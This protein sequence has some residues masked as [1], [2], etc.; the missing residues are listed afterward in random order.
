M[1][2]LYKNGL[3]N[4]NTCLLWS[5]QFIS[6]LG[7]S[8]SSIGIIF[9]VKNH[10][11]SAFHVGIIQSIVDLAP[12][13]F[14]LLSGVFV[15]HFRKK[16]VIVACD[17][18]KAVV[19]MGLAGAFFLGDFDGT[20]MLA[21]TTLA[22]FLVRIADTLFDPAVD[23]LLPEFVPI[24]K[25]ESANSIHEA[26]SQSA[27]ILGQS[28]GAF[29][30]Y[31]L[32]IPLL[33]LVDSISYLIS[34]LLGAFMKPNGS[35]RISQGAERTKAPESVG[36][37]LADGFRYIRSNSPIM[38]T[39]AVAIIF[40]FIVAPFYLLLPF[41]I[42]DQLLIPGEKFGYVMAGSSIGAFVGM[43]LAAKF[44]TRGRFRDNYVFL[45]L[46]VI[47]LNLIAS[48]FASPHI[49]QATAIA[50]VF[51]TAVTYISISIQAGLQRVTTESH[52]GRVFSFFAN[53][54]RVLVPL[55]HLASGFLADQVLGNVG[56]IYQYMGFSILGLS[57]LIF[58]CKPFWVLFHEPTMDAC[59]GRAE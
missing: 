17:V 11:G 29:L 24:Q 18:V 48:N 6:V 13:F 25:L 31:Q 14:G 42:E 55:S 59:S 40:N 28:I 56:R 43:A 23:A 46:A 7:G 34:G 47:G 10:T 33:L 35:E 36:I 26:S 53:A 27:L 21:L 45:A 30:F 51:S 12:I 15:D 54:S 8:V 3:F 41:Y 2:S 38:T 50:L 37:M 22:A 9:W 39:I 57:I 5:S 52:R 58:F 4:R 49:A 16:T 32:G 44:R 19:M 1:H 20:T